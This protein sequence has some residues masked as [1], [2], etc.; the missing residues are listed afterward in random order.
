MVI[1]LAFS[2]R[3]ITLQPAYVKPLLPP[4]LV[5]V[6]LSG[7]AAMVQLAVA[8]NKSRPHALAELVFSKLDG[9][10]AH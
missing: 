6:P 1:S 2:A 9:R 8:M 7:E 5:F 10:N 4:S 3:A